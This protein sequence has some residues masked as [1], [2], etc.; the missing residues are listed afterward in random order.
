MGV[1]VGVAVGVVVDVGIAVF[2]GVGSNPGIPPEHPTNKT[3]KI[4]CNVNPTN[5]LLRSKGF[6]QEKYKGVHVIDPLLHGADHHKPFSV[7]Y[8][9]SPISCI[10]T[11]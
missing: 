5:L 4:N 11:T 3:N 8:Y 6:L 2:E 1:N 7:F 9:R 10:I